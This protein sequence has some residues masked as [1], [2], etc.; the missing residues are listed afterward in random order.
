[1]NSNIKGMDLNL[2]LAFNALYEERS[3]TRAADRLA[4]TQPIVSGMLKRLRDLF[5]DE[6]Y[7]RT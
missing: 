4:L 7:I 2:L 5:S 3:V 6:L 1:M